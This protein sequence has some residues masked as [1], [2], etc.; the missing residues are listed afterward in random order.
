MCYRLVVI[1]PRST[2]LCIRAMPT[3]TINTHELQVCGTKITL[4]LAFLPIK[5]GTLVLS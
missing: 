2:K 4:V 1:V 5:L 3:I